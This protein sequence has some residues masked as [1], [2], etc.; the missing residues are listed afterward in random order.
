M[1]ALW[2]GNI[3]MSQ[4]SCSDRNKLRLAAA[5]A[6]AAVSFAGCSSNEAKNTLNDDLPA[7]T[8]YGSYAEQFR[9]ERAIYAK[10]SDETA[11]TVSTG[12]A[13][14]SQTENVTQISAERTEELTKTENDLFVQTTAGS[15][16][17]SETLSEETSVS[18]DETEE[19]TLAEE[20]EE[21]TEASEKTTETLPE[22]VSETVTSVQETASVTTQAQ[23]T[24]QTTQAVTE[25]Q[26]ESV[27]TAP[28]H[29]D[30]YDVDFFSSD[31]FI[32]DSISTGYSLYGF[33]D[34]K[35]VF[36][37]VGLNPS[38]AATK[39]IATCY[40]EIDV[41]TMLTY[42]NPKRV[43]IMLGSNGIQWLSTGSMLQS[44][45]LLVNLIKEVCPDTNIVIVGVPPVTPKYDASVPD[46][47]IMQLVNDYNASLS[48]YCQ[49]NGLL[50]VDTA[51]VL[52]NSEGYFESAYAESDGMH[53]KYSAY[54]VLLSK[55]QSDVTDFEAAATEETGEIPEETQAAQSNVIGKIGYTE[56][57][58]G[59]TTAVTTAVS[60]SDE[61]VT[62][63][64]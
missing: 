6:A 19:S 63:G 13:A 7:V 17:M 55:I 21:T 12:A 38:S 41:S 32:G 23:V 52:K 37:K 46:L 10:V 58:V 59:E 44:T 28:A 1:T 48:T 62:A 20:A 31:L 24:E 36:A 50:F 42:T 14:G 3:F 16:A 64:T 43:Y 15:T 47:D 54:K 30:V 49:S 39:A 8:Q 53:F 60:A 5:I 33:L 22:T 57:M 2:K 35:N 45:D 9:R 61:T 18:T 11:V 27:V 26:T 56:T 25:Q 34:E 40:G 51:S 29:S 4:L